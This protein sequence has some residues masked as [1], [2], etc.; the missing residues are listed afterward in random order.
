ME[1]DTHGITD[2]PHAVNSLA[3]DTTERN[4]SKCALDLF[5]GTGSVGQRLKEWGYEVISLDIEA[6]MN[7]THVAD[8]L[9]WHYVIVYAPGHF[10][11]IAAGVPYQEYT[12]AKTVGERNLLLAD[13]IVKR[14]W[15]LLDIFNHERGG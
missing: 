2:F 13:H 1:Q 6:G 12:V 14:L 11:L 8:V 5:S 15:R 3:K 9:K 7:P 4:F 10:D